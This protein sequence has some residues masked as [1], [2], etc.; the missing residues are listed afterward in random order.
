LEFVTPGILFEMVDAVLGETQ[1]LFL[2]MIIK[3]GVMSSEIARWNFDMCVE[4]QNFVFIASDWK[5]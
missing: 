3:Y 5:E 1:G 2:N 4:I